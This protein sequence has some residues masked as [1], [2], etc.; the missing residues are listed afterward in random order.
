MPLLP[1]YVVR[2]LGFKAGPE[3]GSALGAAYT[4]I[5]IGAL[6]G[7]MGGV[8]FADSQYKGRI[9]Q[10]AMGAMAVGLLVVAFTHNPMVAYVALGFVGMGAITQLNT[11]NAL[12]QILS[13]AR[14]RG[15]VLAMHIWALNGLSPFGVLLCGQLAAENKDHQITQDLFHRGIPLA[16]AFSGVTMLLGTMAALLS[17]RGLSNLYAEPLTALT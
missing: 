4:A 10:G 15:R 7:L 13:P 1:A 6:F 16:L 5:G 11:T 17:K 9:I 3:S 14:L 2:V 12:F 8:R